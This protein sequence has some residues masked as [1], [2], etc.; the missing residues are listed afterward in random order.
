MTPD[1]RGQH[2]ALKR[3]QRDE[4]E[5][6]QERHLAERRALEEQLRLA[7]AR[8][9]AKAQAAFSRAR[10]P[11]QRRAVRWPKPVTREVVKQHQAELLHRQAQE[12]HEHQAQ[13][14]D[15]IR[16]LEQAWRAELA[17]RR[18]GRPSDPAATGTS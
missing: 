4:R 12:R 18:G 7:Y 8:D 1:E 17:A 10:T 16:P 15:A 9:A 13:Q 11:T 2:H 3:A 14:R 5:A 6:M